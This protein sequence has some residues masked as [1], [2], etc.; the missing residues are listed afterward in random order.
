[1]WSGPRHSALS[2]TSGRARLIVEDPP[3]VPGHHGSMGIAGLSQSGPLL[4]RRIS[5]SCHPS[6]YPVYLQFDNAAKFIAPF[7]GIGLACVFGLSQGIRSLRGRTA[8]HRPARSTRTPWARAS[9]RPRCPAYS[10]RERRL[11]PPERCLGAGWLRMVRAARVPNTRG[12]RSRSIASTFGIADSATLLPART[13]TL[14]AHRSSGTPAARCRA[15][16]AVKRRLIGPLA[17]FGAARAHHDEIGRR[18]T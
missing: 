3:A 10:R 5:N 13:L 6:A 18:W 1:M 9:R 15:R 12:T 4:R 8:L 11:R 17:L 14:I 16:P 7:W 2:S